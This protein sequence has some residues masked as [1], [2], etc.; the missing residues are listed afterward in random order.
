M[1]IRRTRLGFMRQA[2]KHMFHCYNHHPAGRLP[3]HAGIPCGIYGNWSKR[4]KPLYDNRAVSGKG[5]CYSQAVFPISARL[6]GIVALKG[7]ARLRILFCRSIYGT[8]C[9]KRVC[10]RRSYD[11]LVQSGTVNQVAKRGHNEEQRV[12]GGRPPCAAV[13]GFHDRL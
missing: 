12:R 2:A 8:A 1:G 5:R 6:A 11:I 3:Q 9:R 4:R 7:A 13:G 10:L